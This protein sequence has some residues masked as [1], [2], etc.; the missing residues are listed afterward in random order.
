MQLELK[1]SEEAV[2]SFTKIAL[3]GELK[4][5]ARS[6]YLLW[7]TTDPRV[8][9]ATIICAIKQMR[10][11]IPCYGWKSLIIKI[12]DCQESAESPETRNYFWL[13]ASK[14]ARTPDL[15]Q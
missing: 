1:L 4:N 10:R 15:L 9:V 2:T 12:R 6:I 8:Y 13:T 14:A 11:L 5:V 3:A 7:I